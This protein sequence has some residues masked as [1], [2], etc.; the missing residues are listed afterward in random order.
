MKVG[1]S[2]PVQ[3]GPEAHPALYNGSFSG[4]KWP[5]HGV[6]H[7]PHLAPRLRKEYSYTSTSLPLWQVTRW[8]LPLLLPAVRELEQLSSYGDLQVLEDWKIGIQ[9]SCRERNCFL[10]YNIETCPRGTRCVPAVLPPPVKRLGTVADR[11]SITR[12]TKLNI[13]WKYTTT[14]FDVFVV[15]SYSSKGTSSHCTYRHTP[16]LPL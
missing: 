12:N 5:G 16:H 2:E 9:F 14:P 3:S 1:S 7:P 8:T 15:I 4:V 10:L 6:H 11:T 13:A